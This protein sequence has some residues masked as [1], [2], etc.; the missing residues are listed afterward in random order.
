M[1]SNKF[2]W[3][4]LRA[5][6]LQYVFQN[7]RLSKTHISF[8]PVVDFY[9]YF[10][11]FG[12]FLLPRS[13]I[14]FLPSPRPLSFEFFRLNRISSP[15]IFTGSLTLSHQCVCEF[16][17]LIGLKWHLELCVF[18]RSLSTLCLDFSVFCCY[19]VHRVVLLIRQKYYLVIEFH[20][21]LSTLLTNE[22]YT[23]TIV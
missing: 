1:K 13:Y 11:F 16:I 7:K 10:I 23:Q 9:I 6:R 15:S 18:F 4:I 5:Q 19:L 2:Y 17:Y 20:F 8:T 3:I 22:T 14:F 12:A 21:Y